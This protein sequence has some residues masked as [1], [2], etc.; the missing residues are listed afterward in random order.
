MSI[1]INTFTDQFQLDDQAINSNEIPWI[2]QTERSW[3]KPLRFDLTTGSWINLLKVKPGG[4]VNRHRH[5]G[6]KVIAYTL[7]GQW[8]YLER[9][10][11]AKP[12]TFVFEPP[13]DIHTLTV[14]GEEDMITLFI[15]EGSLQ[16]LNDD[17]EIIL[18]EDVFS[19]MKRYIDYCEENNIPVVDL[20]F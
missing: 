3:F 2:P 18:Q 5:T 16:Y 8:R 4:I 15:L 17:D 9:E 6:G 12:G 10:W 7:Q 20:K 1:D 19:K 13:G 11:V 14:D